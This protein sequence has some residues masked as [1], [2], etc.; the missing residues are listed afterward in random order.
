MND[1]F[2]TLRKLA[3][4][5]VPKPSE[6]TRRPT[7]APALLLDGELLEACRELGLLKAEDKPVA[8]L[9]A[10]FADPKKL[11]SALREKVSSHALTGIFCRGRGAYRPGT[12]CPPGRDVRGP[13]AGGWELGHRPAL[14]IPGA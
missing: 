14:D 10:E 13:A 9:W 2:E 5:S 4:S 6:L 8:R 12:I 1:A 7:W 3:E 11:G